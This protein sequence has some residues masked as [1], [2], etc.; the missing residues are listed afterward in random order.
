MTLQWRK[1]SYTGGATDDRCVEVAR[2]AHGIA[3]RDSKH[4]EHGH[5]AL[6]REGFAALLADVRNGE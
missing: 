2:L 6:T 3:V 5:L 4:P 1:S